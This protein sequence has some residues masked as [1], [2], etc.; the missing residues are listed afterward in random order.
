MH[1]PW[2][3]IHILADQCL[4][5]QYAPRSGAFFQEEWRNYRDTNFRV[6]SFGK[7]SRKRNRKGV[8]VWYT[9]PLTFNARDNGA[10]TIHLTYQ[11]TGK[12]ARRFVPHMM[13]EAF[14]G[15]VEDRKE[16]VLWIGGP[17]KLQ[18]LVK[19]KRADYLHANC[20]F[21][22]IVNTPPR[23]EAARIANIRYPA[24]L[25]AD[26]IQ[27][28]STLYA[29]DIWNGVTE[30]FPNISSRTT[31]HRVLHRQARPDVWELLESRGFTTFQFKYKRT[32]KERLRARRY[33]ARKKKRQL[34]H[35]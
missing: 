24:E 22:G 31:F 9:H 12:T 27:Y 8:P 35:V 1:K 17:L 23:A 29:K 3:N 16:I 13:W 26:A 28:A 20:K 34:Q 7:V 6:S 10:P 4:S 11:S 18:N 21:L 2:T 25:L 33:R 5:V 32:L 14:V 30:K 15:P 19:V